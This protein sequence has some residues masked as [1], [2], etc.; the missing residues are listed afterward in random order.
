MFRICDF[1]LRASTTLV[2]LILA[3]SPRALSQNEI[4]PSSS[5]EEGSARSALEELQLQVE[6]MNA[7]IRRLDED[8]V[9]LQA[10]NAALRRELEEARAQLATISDHSTSES[11]SAALRKS[12]PITS[13]QEQ[14]DVDEHLGLV[15]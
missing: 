6:R 1:R 13:E 3:V 2:L 11:A 14:Q 8:T 5:R 9:S 7:S 4:E 10:A 12:T 15:E